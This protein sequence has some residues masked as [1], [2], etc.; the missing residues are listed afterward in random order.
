MQQIDIGQSSSSNPRDMSYDIA[1]SCTNPVDDTHT[2]NTHSYMTT[3]GHQVNI[4]QYFPRVML[5]RMSV[6]QLN[7]Y[8]NQIQHHFLHQQIGESIVCFVQV[9]NCLVKFL[10]LI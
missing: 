7:S 4:D 10:Y 5:E 8:Y 3:D 6:S 9:C 1:L 2:Q